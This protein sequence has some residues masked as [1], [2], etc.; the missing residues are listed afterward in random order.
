[1]TGTVGVDGAGDQAV[2]LE[3]AQRLGEHLLADAGEQAGQLGVAHRPGL[4]GTVGAVG[5]RRCRARTGPARPTCRR[6][7][8]AAGG[9]GTPPGTRCTPP[10]PAPAAA[11]AVVVAIA[12]PLTRRVSYALRGAYFPTGSY[13]TIVEHASTV[14]ATPRRRKARMT[15][16]ST[17]L[18]GGTWTLGD[19][20]VTR[21]GY[22]AMQLAGPVGDG[23]ARRPRR[24]A[25]RAARGRRARHHPHR[26]QRRL[27][28][29][30]HQRADP[31]GAAPLPRVAA[32]RDQ[33]RRRPATPQGGW[34]TARRPEDLRRQV[35][36][37]LDDARRRRARPGQPAAGR[38]RGP[39][40]RLARRG[41]RDARRAAAAGPDPAPRRQQRHRRAGR[42]GAVDRADRVRA[43]HVQPRPP[44]RRRR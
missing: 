38:R 10:W 15:R 25:R 32:H 17:S 18:P 4:A 21:F 37:N 13:L 14:S 40:A 39:A 19:L 42:R 28:P 3:R 7:G 41:V 2:A 33:G 30:R 26:H 20:T 29:A 36:D 23:P 11:A 43:E 5:G 44:P 1:M 16:I 24:R 6:S 31:R 35:H 9:S 27:R 22:G 12:A 34:P 8:R